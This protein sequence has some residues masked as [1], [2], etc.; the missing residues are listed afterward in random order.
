MYSNLV[1]AYYELGIAHLEIACL[2]GAIHDF[3]R[4]IW[5]CPDF[6]M[7]YYKLGVA[8]S[9]L[10]AWHPALEAF[11]AMLR[12]DPDSAHAHF[13]HGLMLSN[14]KYY[15]DAVESFK[16]AIWHE[17]ALS[18]AHIALAATYQTLGEDH[19][20]REQ[21]AIYKRLVHASAAGQRPTD[22][23]RL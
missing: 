12:L 13:H 6:D 11:E 8:Y 1:Q 4:A 7:A 5:L 9:K 20:A 10:G 18:D 2:P 22:L 17:P 15:R 16:L 19:S 14:L 3:K 21:L 23:F